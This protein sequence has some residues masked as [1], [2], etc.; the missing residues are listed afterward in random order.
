MS[1]ESS[2]IFP[3][4]SNNTRVNPNEC[5]IDGRIDAVDSYEGEFWT[6]IILPA[7]DSFSKPGACRVRSKRQLGRP[8]QDVTVLCRVHGFTRRWKDARG[9]LIE[10]ATTYFI[11]VGE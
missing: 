8:G 11:P 3:K 7:A 5:E 10:D 2:S 9:Q 4:P 6:R 1:A